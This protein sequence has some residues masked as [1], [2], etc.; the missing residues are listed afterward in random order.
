MELVRRPAAPP[1]DHLEAW[2]FDLDNTLYPADGQLF[3]QIELRMRQFIAD[4]FALSLDDAFALQKRYL[5]EYGTT[6]RGL[7]LGHGMEPSE[8]LAYVHDI[9]CS[10]LE[11]AP[12]LAA[13]LDC[14]PGRRI[15][16]T[17]GTER[18]ALNV[19]ERLGLTGH[20]EAIFDI[21]SADYIPK[22]NADTYARMTAQHGIDPRRAA[23]FEDLAR[24][25]VPAAAAGMT[26]VL[27]H[28]PGLVPESGPDQPDLLHVHHMTDDLAGWLREAV[29]G[30]SGIDSG[31]GSAAP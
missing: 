21:R 28:P 13:A 31:Q 22:P 20:F 18:H 30:R 4:A 9:D 17:N 14:L 26:T 19:L 2:V 1:L 5:R 7:M 29:A 10:V 11:P 15:I 23:M 3:R 8:F 12:R 25:L 16:F 24:N 6:L 27:V